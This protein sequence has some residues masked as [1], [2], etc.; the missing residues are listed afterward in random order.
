MGETALFQAVEMDS[1][2]Q[3]EILLIKGADPNIS[4][5][6]GRIPLHSAIVKQNLQIVELLLSYGSNPN[7]QG[8]LYGQTP[9]HLAI[10][11][12]VKPTILLLLVKNGGSLL[13]KDKYDKK[14]TDYVETDEM[15]DTINMLK[16]QGEV[17]ETPKNDILLTPSKLSKKDFLLI[18]KTLSDQKTRKDFENYISSNNSEFH[19]YNLKINDLKLDDFLFRENSMTSNNNLVRYN[20]NNNIRFNDEYKDKDTFTDNPG[21]N[22]FGNFNTFGNTDLNNNL[23]YENDRQTSHKKYYSNDLYRD[24]TFTNKDSYYENQKLRNAYSV[25]FGAASSNNDP[26]NKSSNQLNFNVSNLSNFSGIQT[27]NNVEN[28]PILNNLFAKINSPSPNSNANLNNSPLIPFPNLNNNNNNNLN[29]FNSNNNITGANMVSSSDGNNLTRN[30]SSN[31]DANHIS[32]ITHNIPKVSKTQNFANSPNYINN[33]VKIEKANSYNSG[34]VDSKNEFELNK[35]DSS[36]N[37]LFNNEC[38]LNENKYIN[39][40]R[41]NEINIYSD[42]KQPSQLN[43]VEAKSPKFKDIK[44]KNEF[45]NELERQKSSK[46]NISEETGNVRSHFENNGNDDLNTS[47][48]SSQNDNHQNSK[49]NSARNVNYYYK[50][51]YLP[52]IESKGSEFESEYERD[53]KSNKN[54]F[55]VNKYDERLTSHENIMNKEQNNGEKEIEELS[56]GN[57]FSVEIKRRNSNFNKDFDNVEKC[58][59]QD[60]NRK[61]DNCSLNLKRNMTDRTKK[62]Q[63]IHANP[64]PEIDNDHEQNEHEENNKSPRNFS[65]GENNDDNYEDERLKEEDLRMDDYDAE[66][67]KPNSKDC[68]T[69]NFVHVNYAESNSENEKNLENQKNI[70]NYSNRKS[71]SHSCD[72]MNEYNGVFSDANPLD[73]IK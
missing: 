28:L 72:E 24:N 21:L 31:S 36:N 66:E 34:G 30:V 58:F 26:I 1:V 44:N 14:P 2:K 47:N 16:L 35:T 43:Q 41:N 22:N 40:I 18:A 4:Q 45:E 33:Q 13:I 46:S 60:L 54:S 48:H 6:D 71:N 5:N 25:N 37:L 70:N 56:N 63:S 62:N 11:N 27:D 23:I 50:Y 7:I 57:R 42:N 61:I 69:N 3:V 67:S 20:T 49:N 38:L 32:S 19:P 15:R 8:K 53:L 59:S 65:D 51:T 39:K 10:K 64:I 55:V 29:F 68:S 73:T 52:T 12:S 9:V 17:P